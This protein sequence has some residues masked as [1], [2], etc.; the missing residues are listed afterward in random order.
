MPSY[1]RSTRLVMAEDMQI[2]A[3]AR[4]AALAAWAIRGCGLR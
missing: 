4:G 1:K 2:L 3:V